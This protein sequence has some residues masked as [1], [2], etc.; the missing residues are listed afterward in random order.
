MDVGSKEREVE[1]LLVS[2]INVLTRD[3]GRRPDDL[4]WQ[5]RAV[6]GNLWNS[7]ASGAD[8]GRPP[9]EPAAPDSAR[10]ASQM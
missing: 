4:P 8:Q 3:G 2:D 9:D 5:P 7:G 10:R 1:D 6:T